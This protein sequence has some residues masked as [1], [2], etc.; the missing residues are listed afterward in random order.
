MVPEDAPTL[1]ARPQ[2]AYIHTVLRTLPSTLI[3]LIVLAGAVACG[4]SDEAPGPA[5]SP[6]VKGFAL[7]NEVESELLRVPLSCSSAADCTLLALQ[8]EC[9][10]SQ[11]SS[12][13]VAVHR[14][15]LPHYDQANVD[16]RFCTLIR[17]SEYGC[18]AGPSCA[19]GAVACE[20]GRCTTKPANAATTPP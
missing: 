14:A 7:L 5:E 9:N 6:C 12:C 3:L 13:G 19:Q 11:V 18:W 16:A 20:A 1:E 4:S 17:G 10:G 15:V 8:A 2:Q